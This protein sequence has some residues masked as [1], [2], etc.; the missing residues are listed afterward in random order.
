VDTYDWEE[1]HFFQLLL[2]AHIFKM[3]HTCIGIIS[4]LCLNVFLT[5]EITKNSEC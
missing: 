2:H 1:N 5:W 4:L 3:L